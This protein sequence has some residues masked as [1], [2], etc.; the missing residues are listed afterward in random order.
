MVMNS[1]SSSFHSLS[2][3]LSEWSICI[4]VLGFCFP[5]NTC[6]LEPWF[7]NPQG[8]P[9][10][11]FPFPISNP[12]SPNLF[13]GEEKTQFP[14]GSFLLK[15]TFCFL[16]G[17]WGALGNQ[18]GGFQSFFRLWT[19]SLCSFE[20]NCFGNKQG[21]GRG[22]KLQT[23]IWGCWA[24]WWVCSRASLGIIKAFFHNEVQ[25]APSLFFPHLISK[26]KKSEPPRLVDQN[27]CNM[28][29]EEEKDQI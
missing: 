10:F 12:L 13:A 17:D 9:L 2:H 14:G 28:W 27:L 7:Q 19:Q 8:K 6:G 3:H 5:L 16:R 1:C 22:S 26:K 20:H 25:L 23:L 4:S 15:F 18:T 24:L 29:W 21:V 11:E